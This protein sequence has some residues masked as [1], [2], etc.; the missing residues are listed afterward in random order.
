[1]WAARQQHGGIDFAL[2]NRID[3]SIGFAS[4]VVLLVAL[5]LG[6]RR[7]EFV[8][9]ALLAATI[10][11]VLLANAFVCG[12][13]SNPHDRYGA[14]LIWLGPLVAALLACRA[15]VMWEAR[16][17]P[18]NEREDVELATGAAPPG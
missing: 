16:N 2:V 9:L 14:R 3:V 10:T 15:Y 6:W 7:A 1:M 17:D 4:M 5:L 12:V 11:T 18:A 13:L 8:D